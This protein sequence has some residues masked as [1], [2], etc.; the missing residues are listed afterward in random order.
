MITN[1]N[2]CF[3][4]INTRPNIELESRLTLKILDI[5]PILKTRLNRRVT[6]TNIHY[7]VLVYLA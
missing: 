7:R 5:Y 4:T 6:R 2:Y 1:A 3:R